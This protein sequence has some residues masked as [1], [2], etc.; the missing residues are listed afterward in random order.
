[1]VPYQT[2]QFSISKQFSSIWL[3]DK[4]LSGATTPS[5]CEPGS[6][7]NEGLLRIPQSSSITEP[8]TSD[9]LVSYQGH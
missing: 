8:L 3:I 4:T 5:Q 6:D 1:M 2:I 9:Y 7:G